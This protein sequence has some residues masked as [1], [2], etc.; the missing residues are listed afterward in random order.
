MVHKRINTSQ[1]NKTES[2]DSKTMVINAKDT[3][4]NYLTLKVPRK[5]DIFS[6]EKIIQRS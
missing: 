2:R 6:K 1:D 3:I 4:Q 5:W